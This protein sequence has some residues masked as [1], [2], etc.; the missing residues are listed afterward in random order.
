MPLAAKGKN[1][2]RDLDPS[3]DLRNIRI[4]LKRKE[5]LF[6]FDHEFLIAIVQHWVPSPD[7]YGTERPTNN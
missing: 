5:V 4:R 6:S 3:K 7:Q 1:V 2:I